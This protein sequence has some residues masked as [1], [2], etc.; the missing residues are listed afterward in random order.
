MKIAIVDYG[1][2]NIFSLYGALNYVSPA[3]KIELTH[4]KK[5]L[6]KVDLIFLPGVGHF[7]SAMD[8]LIS[9]DLVN[10][11]KELVLGDKKPIMGICLGMQLLFTDSSEG[12]D[13]SGIGLLK[14][15]V[16]PLKNGNEKIPHIGFDT[17]T[18]PLKS[19]MFSN[20]NNYDFYFVHSYCINTVRDNSLITLCDYNEKFIAAVENEHIWGTQ[21]HPEKSQK[22]GLKILKNFI[23]THGD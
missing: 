13:I 17:I 12:G 10:T 5:I 20:I 7:K 19:L 23:E 1:M 2:G 22:S 8:K 16:R 21:F 14:G 18:P 11:I 6:E 3:A 9:L 15:N 4:D